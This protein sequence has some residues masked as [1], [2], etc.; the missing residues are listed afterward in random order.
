MK[1]WLKILIAVVATPIVLFVVLLLSYIII[2]R[3]G[4]I[5]PF[6]LGSSTAEN[7]ILIASQGSEFKIK[8]VENLV[9]QLK[10][11]QNYFS[12]IDCTMLG[13]E[14]EEDWDAIIIIH[15]LQIHEMPEEAKIFLLKVDDLSKVMLVS[16][17]GAG[18]DIV[19]GFDVDAISS[20]SRNSALPEISEWVGK[21][22]QEKLRNKLI[23][24]ENK[25]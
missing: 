7:K 4:V 19:E 18:D 16:T 9:D 25:N 20:A 13:N 2:N 11:N 6:H 23:S 21:K 14:N 15:T 10:G 5:E 22:L 24:I 8:L 12:V 1:K 3:Q 17:S